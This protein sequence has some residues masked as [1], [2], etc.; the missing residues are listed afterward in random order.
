[1]SSGAFGRGGRPGRAEVCVRAGLFALV[2]HVL[3]V[4][5]H[6]SLADGPV[7]WELVA[8]GALVQFAL[9][10]PA[11]RCRSLSLP[12]VMGCTL[13]AQAILHT[14]LTGLRGGTHHVHTAVGHAPGM[15]AAH[16]LAATAAAW[17]LW[18][19]DAALDTA[20]AVR[21]CAAAVLAGMTTPVAPRGIP[22]P[23]AAVRLAPA[24]AVPAR[25]RVL[26]HALVRRGP[27]GHA[28]PR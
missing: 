21:R 23:P 10:L 12:L 19:A 28:V 11:A 9:A 17:L 3:A 5:G 25:A 20:R 26:E 7:P 4:L 24:F 13:T 16:L 22:A 27:P 1:M 15:T 14:A 8:V 2:G 6:H 18:R